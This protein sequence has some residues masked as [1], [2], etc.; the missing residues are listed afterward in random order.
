MIEINNVSFRY[1]GAEKDT[2]RNVNLTIH[3]GECVVLS[4]GSG[5]GKTTITRL[6]N[7]LIPSFYPGE[8]IGT[9][10]IDGQDISNREPYELSEMVGSVF[11]NPRTQFFNTD[12]DSE[13]VFG[14]ENCGIPYEVMHQR[15]Q[16]TVKALHLEKLCARNIFAL[17]GGEKQSIA[18][19]SIFALSPQIYVLDEPSANLDRD[20]IFRLQNV[21]ATLKSMGKTILISEHRLYYLREIADRF[22]LVRDGEITD[23]Y[24]AAALS[25]KTLDQ[26]HNLGLRSL[27]DTN[28][29]LGA[30]HCDNGP[31]IL[32]VR[33]VCVTRGKTEVIHE[34]NME[35]GRGE[36]V[37]IV[38]QN[39]TG[40]TTLA[41]TICGLMRE[42]EGGV[43]FNSTPIK[44]KDRKQH[45][46]LVMQDPNFQLFSDSV[47]AE[48]ELTVSGEKLDEAYSQQLL[49]ELD[50]NAVREKHPLALS[51]GQKQR[52]CIALAALSGAEVLLFDEPTSGLDYKNM[53]RVADM[54]RMLAD[55]GKAIAVISHDNEFLSETCT[56]IVSLSGE[57]K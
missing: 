1:D 50:L 17:S 3:D 5:C 53:R 54:L 30:S 34:A 32:E 28:I 49:R 2:I 23:I 43:F 13:L 14:M 12:T 25:E 15:Y 21:L 19:G 36:I 11:Q 46:F 44:P 42:K 27:Y 45:V 8:L 51:G 10:K 35:V 7:G 38:G 41:R 4:G 56:R 22:I 9:V 52:V 18:F 57:N 26:L 29:T 39:G 20:A 55:R 40:K 6:V 48:L 24:D 31:P 33:N 37:G 47:E 16:E